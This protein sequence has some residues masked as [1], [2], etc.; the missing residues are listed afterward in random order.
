MIDVML[1]WPGASA[2]EVEARL[3]TPVE[4]ELFGL[5]GVDHVYSSAQAGGGL[6]TVRFEVGASYEESLV[7]VFERQT[8]LAGLMPPGALQP[9]GGGGGGG[10]GGG[11]G[12]K[13]TCRSWR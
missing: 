5:A 12:G 4:R 6:V 3:V 11:M 13:T 1:A 7:K 2:A 10:D 9:W 8:A